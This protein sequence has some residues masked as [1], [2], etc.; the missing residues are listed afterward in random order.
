MK[1][2]SQFKA[3]LPRIEEKYVRQIFE[4]TAKAVASWL[5]TQTYFTDRTNN[6]RDSIGV[7]IYKEGVLQTWIENSPRKATQE[8]VTIYHGEELSINGRE[9]LNSAIT[10]A[11]SEAG[12]F[13]TYTMIVFAK[14]PHGE[15]VD[16]GLG[17]PQPADGFKP[18]KKG[19]G[20]WH[21]G[22]VTEVQSVF[23]RE[24]NSVFNGAKT[25]N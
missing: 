23:A 7:G 16:L 5:D 24:F 6:L 10:S 21:D 3:I 12:S 1:L 19:F 13:A 4:N 20:W 2:S 9:L 15:W 17:Y 25:N 18:S 11:A 14:A 8:M 22:L